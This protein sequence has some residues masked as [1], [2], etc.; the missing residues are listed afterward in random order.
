MTPLEKIIRD[1]ITAEGSMPLDRYI[2]LCLGHPQFGYYTTRDP[3]GSAG[4][5]TTSPEISQVFGELIG[6]WCAHVW[7]T[8]GKPP[9]FSLIEL[10][11]GRG[12]LMNDVL[13]AAS[14]MQGF[15]D[16]AQVHLVETSPVLRKIQRACVHNATWHESVANV[17]TLPS[18]ILANEF[19][20]A[21]PIRQFA[22]EDGKVF[23]HCVGIDNGALALGRTEVRI[24][25]PFADEGIFELAPMRAEIASKLG[26]LIASNGGAALVIDYGY[27]K[28]AIGD[29]VQA[30]K[31]HQFC[32]IFESPG[33][34]DVTSHVDFAQLAKSFLKSGA[35]P[36][37]LLTQGEFLNAMGL[38]VRTESLARTQDVV[39]RDGIEKASRRLVDDAEM[40]QLFK[41]FCATQRDMAIPFPFEPS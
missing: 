39:A 7:Q 8:I 29:T 32:S 37:S 5:F 10:G 34:V 25:M 12:T 40:G 33:E 36:C 27:R 13:R 38:L 4:D 23:E 15:S 24:P 20:D 3:L 16:A 26:R 1:I 35:N 41:V 28:S 18:I 14:R 17:P 9:L 19:F 11:P 21:I 30:M 6:V 22:T 2:G 31:Q